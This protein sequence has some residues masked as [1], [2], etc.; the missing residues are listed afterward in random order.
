MLQCH[1]RE[2]QYITGGNPNVAAVFALEDF[3][4]ISGTPSTFARSDLDTPVV[5]H[6]CS[7]CGTGIGSRSPSR[8]NSMIVKIGTFD[9][10]SFFKPQVA[11]F[12]CDKQ[13]YHHIAEGLP[14]FDKRVVKS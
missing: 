2:C 12:T 10:Q 13:P 9:D 3:R 11:I 1:C 8:P 5:R 6:F 4:Y 14:A 7:N